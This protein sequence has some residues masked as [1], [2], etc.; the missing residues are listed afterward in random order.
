MIRNNDSLIDAIDRLDGDNAKV[1]L[2]LFLAKTQ[3]SAL[4]RTALSNILLTEQKTD[5]TQ[6]VQLTEEKI[7]TKSKLQDVINSP[8]LTHLSDIIEATLR[9]DGPFQTRDILMIAALNNK[10]HYLKGHTIEKRDKVICGYILYLAGFKLRS[11]YSR[12]QGTTIKAWKSAEEY[13]SAS[14][15]DR[16]QLALG[17]IKEL[18]SKTDKNLDNLI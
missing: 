12:N 11:T 1:V 5:H 17:R 10:T 8:M 18:Q 14:I 16:I 7:I 9:P 6:L 4:I 3:R 2:K 15:E 13:K